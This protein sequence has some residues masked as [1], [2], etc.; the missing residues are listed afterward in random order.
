M[1]VVDQDHDVGTS[2]LPANAD[3][4]WVAVVMQREYA[5]AR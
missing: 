1:E 4:V 3:V 2:M 5:S